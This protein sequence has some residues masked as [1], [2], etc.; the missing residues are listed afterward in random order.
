MA[1]N[2]DGASPLPF[3]MEQE[4]VT[5]GDKVVERNE[6]DTVADTA[7]LMMPSPIMTRNIFESFN[8][9]FEN[10]NNNHVVPGLLPATTP[11]PSPPPEAVAAT[12]AALF[13]G[14]PQPSPTSGSETRAMKKMSPGETSARQQQKKKTGP[15]IS[16][17]CRVKVTRK[18]LWPILKFDEQRDIVKGYP[19]NYNFHGQVVSGNNSSGY[20]VRFD[21]MPVP[22]K[23]INVGR[24]RLVVV[25][26]NEE[27]RAFDRAKDMDQYGTIQ[28]SKKK[29]IAPMKQSEL[30][31]VALPDEDKSI[32]DFY[33]MIIDKDGNSI[34]WKILGDTEY[35]KAEDDPLKYPEGPVL[36]R[37]I[38]WENKSFSSVFFDEF[39]PSV[40][41]HAKLMDE[42]LADVRASYHT[43]VTNDNIKF[44]DAE[45]DDPDWIIK[46]CY[47][48]LHASVWE[49]DRGLENL[50]RKGKSSGRHNFPDFG[51][52]IP[53]A[54]FRAWQSAAPYMFCDRQYWY[55]ERRNL[56]WNVFL[57]CLDKFNERRKNL[58]Q[59]WLL[60]IDESMSGW[61]PKT[62]K[63]GGLPN[64][65]FEPRKPV[66]L[67]TQLRNGVEC[68]T[69]CLVYQDIV[70]NVEE[71]QSKPFYF[72][73]NDAR[74]KQRLMTSLP[75]KVAMQAHTAEV[76]RQCHGAAVQEGGWVGGDAWFGSVMTCVE[77]KKRLGIHSTFIIKGHTHFFPIG[78]LHSILEARHGNR[79]AGHWVTMT[80]TI[81]DVPIVAVAYAWSQKGVSYFV[82]TCGSTEP[83]AVKYQSKFEDD[84]GNTNVREIDRPQLAHF[85]YEYLP[86]I[87]EHNKQRQSLLQ[88]EKKWLTKDPWFRLLCTLVGMATVDMHRL[89]RYH[90]LHC[91]NLSYKEV[92]NIGVVDFTDLIAGT[93]RKWQY[94]LQR[95]MPAVDD[96]KAQLLV[97][98]TDS[99]GN[100]SR[101][102]TETQRNKGKSV[103]NP[104]T[105]NCFVCRRYLFNGVQKQQTTSWWCLQCQMPLCRADRSVK[106]TIRTTSCHDEHLYS[107]DAILGCFK[108]HARGTPVPDR[109]HIEMGQRRGKRKKQG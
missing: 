85:L 82:S 79:P 5:A 33:E 39:F 49:G 102:P 1:S 32:T 4:Q 98:I 37:D 109:L 48:I 3:P 11:I 97:R 45:D 81:S 14:C 61:R 7:G 100:T 21:Q 93:M 42:Y 106:D 23:D 96:E 34:K 40:E 25:A 10:I 51:Q 80:A 78:V 46:Q 94:K 67:G 90:L 35:L 74:R 56:N 71:Q 66:P 41:G 29:A 87:D 27:E 43:S 26:P 30:D 28:P 99:D 108:K 73:D 31:F 54:Y 70:Q 17:R 38:G 57:P 9:E 86:L 68:F 103:G 62:S 84:W 83:S 64:I 44:H 60:M 36:L 107:D 91:R 72:E 75:G 69:G 59:C 8:A 53:L 19:D 22:F 16:I 65:T 88:L 20:V 24:K 89:Y 18:H 13:G 95:R 52:Y 92:D 2:N 12:A 58:L 50:W 55:E 77:L 15:R 63:L 104:F 105:L 101:E 47:L 76:L 6:V